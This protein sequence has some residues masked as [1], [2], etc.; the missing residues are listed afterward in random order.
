MRNPVILSPYSLSLSPLFQSPFSSGAYSVHHS[1][2]KLIPQRLLPQGWDGPIQPLCGGGF[3]TSQRWTCPSDPAISCQL[4]CR[5]LTAGP[6]G[7][8]LLGWVSNWAGLSPDRDQRG[9]EEQGDGPTA[10]TEG[11]AGPRAQAL[12]WQQTPPSLPPEAWARLPLGEPDR[13]H[14]WAPHA[15]SVA[16]QPQ[17]L[18][19][20]SSHLT[21]I[22]LV[23][24]RTIVFETK[25]SWLASQ[26]HTT[27]LE[28]LNTYLT[29]NGWMDG[30]MD[31][32]MDGRTDGQMDRQMAGS[33][34]NC[35]ETPMGGGHRIK[36]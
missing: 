24:C 12:C 5:G 11:A 6:W 27:A 36:S 10:R 29:N 8:W 32:W 23:V 26:Y 20:P 4:L 17:V 35:S 16:A 34:K 14:N 31:E 19:S 33:W 1:L 30:W 25:I 9:W 7:W 13:A 18:P 22:V 15:F 21:F 28:A 2:N 3:W